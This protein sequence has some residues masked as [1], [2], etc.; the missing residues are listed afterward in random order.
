MGT[1]LIETFDICFLT[2]WA[3]IIFFYGINSVMYIYAELYCRFI[4][5]DRFLHFSKSS[6]AMF[7]YW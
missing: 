3:V 7:V 4:S 1:F 6:F 5:F 2:D